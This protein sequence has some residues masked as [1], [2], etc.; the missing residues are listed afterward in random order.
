MSD[1]TQLIVKCLAIALLTAL[2]FVLFARECYCDSCPNGFAIWLRGPRQLCR[3][4]KKIE[5]R[6]T[7][8]LRRPRLAILRRHWR[9]VA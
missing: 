3:Q 8:S 5:D 7:R 2:V 4:C 6:R 1:N 9:N